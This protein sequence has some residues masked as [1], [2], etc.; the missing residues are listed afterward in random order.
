MLRRRHLE[1]SIL[2]AAFLAGW[3]FSSLADAA[4]PEKTTSPSESVTLRLP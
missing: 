4:Q 3:A 2:F 1:I